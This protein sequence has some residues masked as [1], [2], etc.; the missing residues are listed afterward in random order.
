MN[1]V[2]AQWLGIIGSVTA[3]VSIQFKNINNIL[4]SQLVINLLS[5]VSYALL[6]GKSGAWICM[7]AIA[8]TLIVFL[9]NRRERNSPK[10]SRLIL[11]LVFCLIYLSGTALFYQGWGDLVS[12]VCALIFALAIVQEDSN[13]FRSLILANCLLW[14]VYDI[15]TKAYTNMLLQGITVMSILAAI[16]RFRKKPEDKAAAGNGK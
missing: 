3:L 5:A 11:A 16:Y 2:I 10:R 9:F 1:F 12:G 14:V 6:G 13:R 4:I 15:T 8:Q 7:F